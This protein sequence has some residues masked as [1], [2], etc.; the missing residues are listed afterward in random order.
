MLVCSSPTN[1]SNNPPILKSLWYFP[2]NN[3]YFGQNHSDETLHL[4]GSDGSLLVSRDQTE[5]RS[6]KI[7]HRSINQ[8]VQITCQF[9]FRT[10][11]GTVPRHF[12]CFHLWCVWFVDETDSSPHNNHTDWK[13]CYSPKLNKII[14]IRNR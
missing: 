14:Y 7:R 8:K 4:E 1:S 13:V 2:K 9:Q 3:Y 12:Q 10:Y 6:E 5:F 11:I